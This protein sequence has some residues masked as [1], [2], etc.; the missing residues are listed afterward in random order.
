MLSAKEMEHHNR[1]QSG[2]RSWQIMDKSST[3]LFA[4]WVKYM[5]Y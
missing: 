3:E 1:A 2:K 5:K 4:Q